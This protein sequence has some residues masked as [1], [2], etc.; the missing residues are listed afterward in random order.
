[1]EKS[2]LKELYKTLLIARSPIQDI[3]YKK[4]SKTTGGK[5]M[6]CSVHSCD[7]YYEEICVGKPVIKVQELQC[8][9]R[10]ILQQPAKRLQNGMKVELKEAL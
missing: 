7:I 3:T 8:S 4:Y 10:P 6:F 2:S 1:M 5:T 9:L